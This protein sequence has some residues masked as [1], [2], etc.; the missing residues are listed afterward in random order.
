MIM[1]KNFI[2]LMCLLCAFACIAC[3]CTQADNGESTESSTEYTETVADKTTDNSNE[4]TDIP[5]WKLSC[6]TIK[7]RSNLHF[8]IGSNYDISLSFAKDW[9]LEN[10]SDG[11][12]FNIVRDGNVIG[13][14]SKGTFE[15]SEW[16]EEDKFAR[17]LDPTLS[18]KKFI[19]KKGEGSAA[20]YRYR[21]EYTC[22]PTATPVV[23]SLCL[24][25]VE[26][27]ANAADRLYKSPA[28]SAATT[29]SSGMLS[30]VKDGN[31]LILGNSFIGS[32]N[33]GTLLREMFALNNKNVSFNAVSRGYAQVGTYTSDTAMMSSIEGGQ[34][35]AV[36]IC[37]FY[38]N[39]EANNLVTLEKA[40]KKS[41]TELI[42]FP[43]HNEFEDPIKTARNKCPDLKFLNWKGELDM[44]IASGVDKW[45]LCVNDAHLHSTE[46]AGLIGAH[47]M[48]R[49]IYGEIPTVEGMSSINV[50]V[51]K[52]LFGE[53]LTTGCVPVDYEVIKLN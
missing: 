20:E 3:S 37:G 6:R 27:D 19:E 46:Y 50:D 22:T 28:I 29:V 34:Y 43:A 42:I 26:L 17:T 49:A 9:K 2:K 41:D 48:Y 14:L 23:L 44:L 21:F 8:D 16:V 52:S 12:F 40:C 38:A 39:A 25:Y 18:V 51:A 5:Y 7:E 45:Q 33:I 24:N 4:N 31:Y 10:S 11:T 1:K 47:M 13:K 30:N 15:D 53:Y 32:S 36:F 35:D